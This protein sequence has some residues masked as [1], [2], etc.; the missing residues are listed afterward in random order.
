MNTSEKTV[1][2]K[3]RV[4]WGF[5]GLADNF[6][7]NTL[8]AMGTLIY[9]NHFKMS[10]AL[11][12]IALAAPR[13]MDAVTDILIGN[14]SDNSK[15][16]FGRRKPFMFW[17]VLLSAILLPL[18]WTPLGL[19]TVKSE[20]FVNIPF[21]Y[22]CGIGCLLAISYTLFVVPYTAMGLELTPDYDER[23]K[24]MAWR[25]YIGLLGSLAAGWLFRIAADER[26]SDLGQGALIVTIVISVIV[27]ISGWI[28]T[29]R[30]QEGKHVEKQEK[31]K[32]IPALGEAL[33][34]RSFVFLFI[35]YLSII[36][37]L[38][39]AQ[40]FAP[41]L[42]Q[43]HVFGGD[44]I[45]IGNFQGVFGTLAFGLS[46]VSIWLITAISVKSNKRNA[47]ITGLSLIVSG[48]LLNYFAIDPRWPWA[49]YLTGAIGLF[50]MQGCWLMVSSMLAD[51]CDEDELKTGL[52][53]EGM[54]SAIIGFALKAGQALA[55]AVGGVFAGMAGFDIDII[56][57]VGMD[58][59]T[60]STMKMVL[61]GLQSV[62]ILIS[63]GLFCY[64]P[65][66]RQKSE[67]TRRLLAERKRLATG[68]ASD[69]VNP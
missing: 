4:A 14:W 35:A 5:G 8:T 48:T 7:F 43:H 2:L 52:R 36:I 25:M 44:N 17:G 47:M 55:F 67:E 54:Y 23:T 15:S 56:A 1:S 58:Q 31:I 65:I 28:P 62:G 16:K 38:F 40:T 50:G 26:F 9:V 12:G 30:V 6:M 19:D 13:L 64:Y 27:L 18:L 39:S 45:K 46:Y 20:W 37:A 34:N 24:V 63:I 57:E 21:L 60:A 61:V 42:Y 11:A 66:T 53:R 41:L 68:D 29:F 22:V 59:S 51:V 3:T 10:P 69:A 49:L 32:L 33:T